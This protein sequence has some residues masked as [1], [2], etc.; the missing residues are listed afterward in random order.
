MGGRGDRE[1]RPAGACAEQLSA[2]LLMSFAVSI[3]LVR[4]AYSRRKGTGRAMTQ[5]EVMLENLA[6][7]I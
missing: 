6:K 5:F 2:A 3:A 1:E 7:G 4:A